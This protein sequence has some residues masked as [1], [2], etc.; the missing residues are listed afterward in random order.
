METLKCVFTL[1]G[2]IKRVLCLTATLGYQE[3]F[4]FSG[5]QDCTIKMWDLNT[6]S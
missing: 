1:A 4:L 6:G 3:K 2:H 5:S